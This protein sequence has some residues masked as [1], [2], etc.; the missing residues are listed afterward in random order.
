MVL[1]KKCWTYCPQITSTAAGRGRCVLPPCDAWRSGNHERPM[2]SSDTISDDIS[3]IQDKLAEIVTRDLIAGK[4]TSLRD[5]PRIVGIG[6]VIADLDNVAGTIFELEELA[7]DLAEHDPISDV[8]IEAAPRHHEIEAQC[9]LCA[10]PALAVD[11]HSHLCP[12]RRAVEWVQT[13]EFEEDVERFAAGEEMG[14]PLQATL[15]RAV[16]DAWAREDADAA[17][18]EDERDR[19]AEEDA[20][21]WL[22]AAHR[23]W[24]GDLLR[25]RL[26]GDTGKRYTLEEVCEILGVSQEELEGEEE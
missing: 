13:Q 10:R 22:A 1:D 5:A 8:L 18:S 12:W 16:D 15:T 20:V 7:A 11:D 6:R 17:G 25:A 19:T 2:S 24:L 3:H 21:D 14:D 4:V 26:A 23:A 9:T